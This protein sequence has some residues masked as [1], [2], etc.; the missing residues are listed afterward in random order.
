[1]MDYG[2]DI[3]MGCLTV[4]RLDGSEMLYT[5]F[6]WHVKLMRIVS[7]TMKYLYARNGVCNSVI[8]IRHVELISVQLERWKRELPACLRMNVYDPNSQISPSVVM[9]NLMCEWMN[10]L[11]FQPFYQDRSTIRYITGNVNQAGF[12]EHDLNRVTQLRAKA[13][14]SATPAADRILLLIGKFDRQHGLHMMDNTS[15]QIIYVA[16]KIHYLGILDNSSNV[17]GTN[18]PRDGMMKAIDYLRKMGVTWPS[19]VASADRL[20]ELLRSASSATAILPSNAAVPSSRVDL[21]SSSSV[22]DV[23]IPVIKDEAP[24]L[25]IEPE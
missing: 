20:D 5:A 10:I 2:T 18:S 13:F 12:S 19:A 17:F 15:V 23:K 8:D 24:T 1:M 7:I 6:T 3:G 14:Q 4:Q 11:L 25:K 16:G 9:V 21:V 22:D